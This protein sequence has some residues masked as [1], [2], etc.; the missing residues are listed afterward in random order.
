MNIKWRNY[1]LYAAIGSLIAMLANDIFGVAPEQ[2][3]VYVD[4]VLG[5]LIAAGIISNPSKGKGFK[6]EEGA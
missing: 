6:D 5:V 3:E 1:G 2:T 4:G